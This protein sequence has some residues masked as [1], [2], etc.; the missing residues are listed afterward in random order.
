MSVSDG[1]SCG[2]EATHDTLADEF[3]MLVMV[4]KFHLFFF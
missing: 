1:E 3:K 4:V 2:R